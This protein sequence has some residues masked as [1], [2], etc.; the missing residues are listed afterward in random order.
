MTV[1]P[2]SDSFSQL[3]RMHRLALHDF[4]DQLSDHQGDFRAWDGDLSFIGLTDHLTISS[5]RLL[6]QLGNAAP[7]SGT[8]A[9]TSLTEARERL[10]SST[11]QV[12]TDVG[13]LGPAALEREVT[14]FHGARMTV[15]A[16]LD[17]VLAH[18]AHHKG[19]VW[20]MARLAGIQPPRYLHFT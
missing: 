12:L 10:A 18:E 8:L 20:V 11:E 9:S 16:L 19:Q 14:A 5:Q 3:F 17:I 7:A 4:Y 15:A 2:R 13:H 6:T 1:P